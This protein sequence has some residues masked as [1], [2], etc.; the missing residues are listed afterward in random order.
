MILIGKNRLICYAGDTW[1]SPG[2]NTGNALAKDGMDGE[3]TIKCQKAG[4]KGHKC[5]D[6]CGS[7][8]AE[9][10]RDLFHAGAIGSTRR[11]SNNSSEA[12]FLQL[13]H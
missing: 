7:L 10:N 9:G 5:D 8:Y 6:N 12:G 3:L 4:Q 2:G 1:D 13:Y 11:S